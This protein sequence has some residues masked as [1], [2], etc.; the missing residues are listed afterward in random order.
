MK[1]KTPGWKVLLA[2]FSILLTVLVWQRGLQESFD[3]PSVSPKLVLNQREMA[4]LAEP[5]LPRALRP[6]LVG[7]DPKIE[8]KKTLTDLDVNQ[9]DARERLL[10]ASIEESDNE[11]RSLL[12][13]KFPEPSL[14]K[15]RV[16]L[17]ESL[18][19]QKNPNDL[20]GD[21]E[22]VKADPLLYRLSCLSIGGVPESC[23]EV[24]ASRQMALRLTLSQL[25]PLLAIL[26]GIFLLIWQGW[27][28]IR[29]TSLPWPELYSLPLSTIDLVLLVAGGF[30][31]LGELFT[32]LIALP[33][34]ESFI[35]E[36]PS[37]LKESL[38]VLIGYIAMTVPPL[39]ILRQQVKSLNLEVVEGGW[40]QWGFGTFRKS[41]LEALKGWL[42]VMPL[43]L[44][45]S[46]LTTFF[47]GDPGGSNPL[48][49]MVLSSRNFWALSVLF[50]TTVFMAPFFEELIFRGVLL[51][52]LLNK[53]G[54]ILAIVVSALIFALAHLSVGEMP[55][56]FVLG[57]GLAILRLTS[58]RL[59]PCVLMHSLWNGVTFANLL[60]L[61]G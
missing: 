35:R 16:N 52:V 44:L 2:T 60:I 11:R 49:E 50:V 20:L 5:S 41:F 45:V 34:S 17:L 56:L 42:M 29:K 54:K 4:L 14:E 31:V 13:E 32:P 7:E 40:I 57:M 43:V 37:P 27:I 15:V 59:L 21:L 19:N 53:Q 1:K 23:Y 22:V 47:L 39:L 12:N 61:S 33:L 10:L 36:V 25:L 38:K 30:V 46:W 51:P 6:L 26:F 48:L 58:G 55:P 9:L 3:R 18:Q 24:S 28:F 8:L